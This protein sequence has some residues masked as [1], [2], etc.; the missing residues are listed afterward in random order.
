MLTHEEYH[1]NDDE[2]GPAD[3][4]GIRRL[5]Y[6][7]LCL[8]IIIAV[9]SVAMCAATVAKGQSDFV[10]PFHVVV[11]GPQP[12]SKSITDIYHVPTRVVITEAT[13]SIGVDSEGGSRFNYPIQGIEHET[14]K[15]RYIIPEG[16]IIHAVTKEGECVTWINSK[17]QWRLYSFLPQFIEIEN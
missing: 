3:I 16:I 10:S 7:C 14:G 9:F 12:G 17:F 8:A 13:V 15:T 2:I 11:T 4:S 5:F 1:D 6:N